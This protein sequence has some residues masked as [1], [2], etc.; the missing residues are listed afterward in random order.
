MKRINFKYTM[1]VTLTLLLI[2]EFNSLVHGINKNGLKKRLNE[3]LERLQI[4][5]TGME[6]VME[7][8]S[9]EKGLFAVKKPEDV[10]GEDKERLV[11]LWMSYLDH[12]VALNMLVEEYKDFYMINYFTKRKLHA[13]AYLIGYTAYL[14]SYNNGI[15]L[16]D[17]TI[18]NKIID[19]I[20]NDSYLNYGVPAGM[21]S[22][23][24]WNV[25][26]LN[27]V[28]RLTAGYGNYKF[29]YKEYKKMGLDKKYSAMFRHIEKSYKHS[30]KKLKKEAVVWFPKNGLSI[31]KE[32][33]YSVWFPLQKNV[34][35]AL[36]K[37]RVTTRD[38]CF[39]TKE[40]TLEMKK[41]MKPGDVM[42]ERKNWYTSNIGIPGFWTHAALY[43]GTYDEFVAYFDK[44]EIKEYLK[45]KGHIDIRQHLESL[46]SGFYKKYSKGKMETI[47][48]RES[49]VIL[50]TLMESAA[51][52]YVGVIRPKM[53]DLEK[54]KGIC[55]VLKHQGKPYD[56]HFSLVSDSAMFCYEL[57]YKAYK[58]VIDFETSRKAGKDMI[59]GADFI[60][61][62]DKGL[63]SGKRVFD[64][65]YFLDGS[66]KE[67]RAIVRGADALR[68]TWQRSKWDFAQK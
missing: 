49:G 35:T 61:M 62:F 60:E 17:L 2:F 51:A 29:L 27:D 19:E 39:V 50:M 58:D 48:A 37:A 54:F 15:K 30:T 47:E 21:Y 24:K 67:K 14:T 9:N 34:A 5:I 10:S 33:S 8:I 64:F 56:Y 13:K 3:D 38:G 43:L 4:Y 42:V 46:N 26:H 52:D 36:G 20:L 1:I 44:P 7:K 63:D 32:K 25:L 28:V 65:V 68:K 18:D 6:S 55:A 59:T 57:I 41:S 23:L 45:S 31:F 22:K 53:S 11:R 12:Q 16:I 66:E 40:Q